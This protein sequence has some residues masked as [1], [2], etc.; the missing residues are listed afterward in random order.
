MIELI[1]QRKYGEEFHTL[2]ISA[3]GRIKCECLYN[4]WDKGRDN[5]SSCRHVY[6]LLEAIRKGDLEKYNDVSPKTVDK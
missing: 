4:L 5:C 3:D 1:Y 2:Y 6:D